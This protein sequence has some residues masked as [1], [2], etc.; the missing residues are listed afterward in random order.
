MHHQIW[1][2]LWKVGYLCIKTQSNKNEKSKFHAKQFN[3]RKLSK[4][5]ILPGG[6]KENILFHPL[7]K[8]HWIL[9]KKWRTGKVYGDQTR[10]S[11]FGPDHSDKCVINWEYGLSRSWENSLNKQANWLLLSPK[12]SWKCSTLEDFSLQ[13]SSSPQQPLA[14]PRVARAAYSLT[15]EDR[16]NHIHQTLECSAGQYHLSSAH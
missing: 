1:H 11:N 9:G 10:K 5:L 15:Q 12:Q 2:C 8:M 3:L 16:W 4:G 7:W 14:S 6:L 13:R